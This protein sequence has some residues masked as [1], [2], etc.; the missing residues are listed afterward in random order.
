VLTPAAIRAIMEGENAPRLDGF[1]GP[2][3]VSTMIGAEAYAP[4]ALAYKKPIVIAGFEPIDMLD[5]IL[6]LVRQVNRGEAHIENAYARAAPHHANAC[7]MAMVEETMELRDIFA[8]RGLG[9]IP[10]S[11]LRV[12]AAYR[13][14]DAEHRFAVADRFVP[15]HKA[16]ECGAIL[17]GQKRPEDC[18]V[19]AGA[20]TPDHP[21]GACMVS[22]EGACAAHYLYGRF[23]TR[24]EARV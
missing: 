20:C 6:R 9:E 12:A 7:A 10:A 22:S 16:C 21:I 17:R 18:K 2:G 5:A 13:D 11:A 23:R 8:W 14:M 4:A 24:A 15:D 19:F 3:H 1:V